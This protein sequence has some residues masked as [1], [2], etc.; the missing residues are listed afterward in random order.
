MSL[1]IRPP[2]RMRRRLG[3]RTGRGRVLLVGCPRQ[4]LALALDFQLDVGRLAD[5]A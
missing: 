4:G 5:V 1:A 2:G 3:A